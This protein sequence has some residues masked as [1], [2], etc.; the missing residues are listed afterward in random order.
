MEKKEFIIGGVV[1]IAAAGLAYYM[2]TTPRKEEKPDEEKKQN[3]APAA[4]N[5]EEAKE[6]RKVEEAKAPVVADHRERSFIMVKPDGVQRSKISNVIT[7]FE[8]RGFK[9]IAM[10]LCKPGE[11]HFKKHYDDLK[12]KPFF[13]RLCK[14]AASG[15]VL[16]MV[17]EGDNVIKTGRKLIGATN[18]L[19]REPGTIR[20]DHCLITSNN[21]IHGSDCPE[22]A[23]AEINLWFKPSELTKWSGNNEKWVYEK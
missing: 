8:R 5:L 22:A 19:Q 4:Q 23:T 14:F 12:D 1:A 6:E 2:A 10:K 3:E 7:T 18:E 15:P 11:A 9:L 20:A 21:I 17:W 16:A 13:G